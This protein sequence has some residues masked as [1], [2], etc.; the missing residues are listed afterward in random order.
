MDKYSG[1]DSPIHRLD[2]R[3]KILSLFCLIVICV[4][5][6]PQ[7][8]LGF[9]GYFVLLAVA[10]VLSRVPLGYI[11]RRSLVIIPF[12]IMVTIFIPFLKPNGPGSSYSLGIGGLQIYSSGL[13]IFWNVLVKSFIAVLSVILLSSTTP[14]AKLLRGF[15]Q[16]KVPGIFIML[17]SFTY[18]YV[19]VLVDEVERMK[20]ARDCRCYGGKWLWHSKVIGQMIGTLF[21]RSY[22]RGERIYVAMV[23]RGFDGRSISLGQS[24]LRLADYLVATGA[25]SLLVLLRVAIP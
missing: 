18:R 12:V 15:E 17:A 3:T 6:P 7:A 10:I 5:T 22:Q 21:L 1:L 14:F 13:M 4:S 24:Q 19:F 8:Y 20:R 16:L 9:L 2:A 25:V 11:L 23:S